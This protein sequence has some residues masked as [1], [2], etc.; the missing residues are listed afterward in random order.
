MSSPK[1]RGGRG[2]STLPKSAPRKAAVPLG[3]WIVLAVL[4]LG[5]VAELGRSRDR[6]RAGAIGWRTE[7]VARAA[8][9]A[10]RAPRE[11]FSESLRLLRLAETLDPSDVS[12]PLARG[13]QHLLL[14]SGE[15]A[16]EAYSEALRL[17]PRPEIYLN[18]G[19]AQLLVRQ[20][21]AARQSF[22]TAVRLDPNLAPYV[23]TIP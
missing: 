8:A 7:G 17:E 21:A 16:I 14:G 10:G 20:N 19:R 6:L 2:V 3:S 5:L 4:A 23:P 13:S 11:L 9:S 22:L 18:L 1:K 15:A 12:L